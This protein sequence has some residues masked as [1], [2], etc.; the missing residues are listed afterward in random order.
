MPVSFLVRG[1]CN[2]PVWSSHVETHFI[3]YP[4]SPYL[5]LALGSC[6]PHN[7]NQTTE[8]N[9]PKSAMSTVASSTT[10]LL[11]YVL[12][13]QLPIKVQVTTAFIDHNGRAQGPPGLKAVQELL[14]TQ[15]GTQNITQTQNVNEERRAP[16]PALPGRVALLAEQVSRFSALSHR[17]RAANTRRSWTAQHAVLL[18]PRCRYP[19]CHIARHAYLHLLSAPTARLHSHCKTC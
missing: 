1:E 17:V 19:P 6:T 10:L 13:A 3:L 16:L 18:V 5:T 12:L 11:V 2:H 7:N 15:V 14:G 4:P 8:P 9:Q